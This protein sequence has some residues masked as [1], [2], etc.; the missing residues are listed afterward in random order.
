MAITKVLLAYLEENLK[1]ELISNQLKVVNTFIE[2]QPYYIE[3]FPENTPLIACYRTKK[4]PGLM[5][6]ENRY[7]LDFY[8]YFEKTELEEINEKIDIYEEI[9]ETLL[10]GW[11]YKPELIGVDFFTYY[12]EKSYYLYSFSIE[13][14]LYS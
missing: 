4:I 1:N 12:A 10:E 7:K 9:I 5:E 14:R 6:K 2:F 11:C 8:I 3:E 13:F